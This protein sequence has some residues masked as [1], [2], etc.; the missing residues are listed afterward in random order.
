M[1]RGTAQEDHGWMGPRPWWGHKHVKNK[2][3]FAFLV[4][5]KGGDF[6]P[7][8]DLWAFIPI[9]LWG[10]WTPRS[11][12]K[13]I[14]HPWCE[15]LNRPPWSQFANTVN[16]RWIVMGAVRPSCRGPVPGWFPWG[17]EDVAAGMRSAA[18]V[19]PE[20]GTVWE[21][22]KHKVRSF[23]ALWRQPLGQ[24]FPEVTHGWFKGFSLCKNHG[25]SQAGRERMVGWALWTQH[26]SSTVT[27]T[28]QP[29]RSFPWFQTQQTLPIR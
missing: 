20:A 6:P 23:W 9:C 5:N 15:T 22:G 1:G 28:P 18:V 8:P 11:N 12:R 24:Y 16:P 21:L 4:E 17:W 14:S 27:S 10:Q 3:K 26:S 29:R 25:N 19:W 2:N 7:L 13:T